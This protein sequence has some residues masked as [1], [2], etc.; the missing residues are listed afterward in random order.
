M[1][2][3][4]PRWRKIVPVAA[5]LFLALALRFLP[6]EH[7]FP[8]NYV[9]DTHA[10]RAALG[11]A[12]DHDLAPRVGKYSSYPY[13]MPYMLLPIYGAQ[14]ALGKA[15]GEWHG[16]EEFGAVVAENPERVALP[17]RAL[18]ALFGAL[19]ALAVYFAARAAGLQRGALAAMFLAATA[20][21]HVQ[22]SVQ[23]RPWAIVVFFGA[24]CSWACI[25]FAATGRARSL[26]LSGACAGLAFAAHQA[27]LFFAFLT[28]CTW[29]FC[30]RDEADW[31]GSVLAKRVLLALQAALVCIVVGVVCG[32]A[33][34][35]V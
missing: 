30:G 4:L 15:R 26:V 28:A 17:A 24:L 13:L 10:V 7:G 18:V 5:V 34:Y 14:Y 12:K 6:L 31:R 29:I 22:M 20:L 1:S 23:E 2:E 27:G 11:M 35:L 3:R 25:H 8:R 21:L 19:T 16:A 9:P 33:Y 32:H